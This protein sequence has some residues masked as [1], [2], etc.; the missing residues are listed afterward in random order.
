MER[1]VSLHTHTLFL[2]HS[3][4]D[5][6]GAAVMTLQGYSFPNSNVLDT[7]ISVLLTGENT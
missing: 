4:S 7:V 1:F 3:N 5:A 6:N 2:Q